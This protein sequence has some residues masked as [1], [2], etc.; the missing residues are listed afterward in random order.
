MEG[1][2]GLC[3]EALAKVHRAEFDLSPF[4]RQRLAEGDAKALAKE[5]Y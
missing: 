4:S 1:E 5:E 2:S 3:S